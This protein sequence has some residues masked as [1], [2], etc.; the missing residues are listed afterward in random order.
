M[1]SAQGWVLLSLIGVF[2]SAVV[3][4]MLYSQQNLKG[5]LGAKVE[6][7]E[8]SLGGRID[9]LEHELGG[10]IDAVEHRLSGRID[11]VEQKLASLDRDVQTLIERV[12]R[13]RP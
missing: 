12:F 11:G 5:Y 7:V 8:G 4:V 1:N 2:A 9:A 6:G 10:R 3:T 13:D